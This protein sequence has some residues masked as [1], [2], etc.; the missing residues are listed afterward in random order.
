MIRTYALGA[1]LVFFTAIV[2]GCGSGENKQPDTQSPGN[3]G[4]Q[5]SGHTHE[6]DDALFWQREGI[7]HEGYVIKL[8]HHGLKVY[9]D[10]DLEPAVS[11]TRDGE[12]VTDAK[13][14]NSLVAADRKTVLAAEVA[15]VY[16][17]ATDEEEAHFAQGELKVPGDVSRV[18][19]RYRIEL[20]GGSEYQ[21]DVKVEAEK[22]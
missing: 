12:P 3:G 6:G 14:F 20:P 21:H 1:V 13:V 5:S 11:V 7:E 22:H 2:A 19:I 9:A 8:G 17:P 18:I 16:E 15:T 10:H 4:K